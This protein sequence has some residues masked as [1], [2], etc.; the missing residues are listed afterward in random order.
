VALAAQDFSYAPSVAYLI[1]RRLPPDLPPSLQSSRT[2]RLAQSRLALSRNCRAARR[3]RAE[4][5]R[6]CGLF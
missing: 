6:W 3:P 4:Q 2:A 5:R 1:L